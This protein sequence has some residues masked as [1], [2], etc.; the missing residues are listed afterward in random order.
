[1]YRNLR[2]RGGVLNLQKWAKL[3]VVFLILVTASCGFHPGFAPQPMHGPPRD[4]LGWVAGVWQDKAD[5][6]FFFEVAGPQIL[7]ASGGRIREAATILRPIA[8]GLLVCEDGHEARLQVRRSGEQLHL[9]RARE[10][11]DRVLTRLAFRPE[12]LAVALHLGTPSPLPEEKVLAIQR[13]IRLRREAEHALFDQ[14]R[15]QPLAQLP[16]LQA[17]SPLSPP[18]LS[19][20]SPDDVRVVARY[21][22]NGE[23]MRALVQEVGW[24]D[25]G[26]FGYSA[27][28]EAFFLVQHSSDLPLLLAVLPW[29]QKDAAAGLIAGSAYALMFD[30]IQ[31]TLGRA[32]RF[33]SQMG[34]GADGGAIVL[35]LEDPEGAD[36]RRRQWGMQPLADYV[37]LALP[38]GR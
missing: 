11:K 5:P 33:G 17:S 21:G 6:G 32:Q 2:V 4:A 26:R 29:I 23:Y 1:M 12:A 16:W 10:G 22:E 36:A 35:P 24:V 13:E 30:R 34:R 28:H 14:R 7:I 31:L 37:R 38:G 9:A 3:A 25:V 15:P 27:S 20:G 8:A 19:S 18:S